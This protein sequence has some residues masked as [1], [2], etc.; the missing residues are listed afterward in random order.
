MISKQYLADVTRH[1]MCDQADEGAAVGLL[2]LMSGL[3]EEH[4]CAG[5]I[6]GNEFSLW[7]AANGCAASPNYGQGVITERQAQLLRVLH[8]EAGGWWIYDDGPQFIPSDKWRE[9]LTSAKRA[10]GPHP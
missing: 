2:A 1:V 10:K 3:S 5:W 7:N 4:W 6:N 9:I 8:D